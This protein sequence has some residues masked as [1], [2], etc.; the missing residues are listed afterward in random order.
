MR[1]QAVVA[2]NIGPG[3]VGEKRPVFTQH[4]NTLNRSIDDVAISLL[5][6]L[7]Q[8]L[9]LVVRTLDRRLRFLTL[10][11][12]ARE[13]A[14]EFSVSVLQKKHRDFER[15][16]TTILAPMDGLERIG[17]PGFDAIPGATPILFGNLGVD[18][19]DFHSGEILGAIV[20]NLAGVVVH[21][22]EMGVRSDPEDR[23]PGVV[24][25]DLG[26]MQR[27]V[28]LFA[29]GEI[30]GYDKGTA[31][32]Q[33]VVINTN[34]TPVGTLK[35]TSLHAVAEQFYPTRDLILDLSF[36]SGV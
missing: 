27:P 16:I 21:I 24:E 13:A 28:G 19:E 33:L 35:F 32:F 9:Q 31:G 36:R 29:R 1:S 18:V 5:G 7:P 10:G 15:N 2:V 14:G 4:Q 3:L 22:F 26:Q 34:P 11:D 25:G 30:R 20:E 6:E 17:A 12:V 8:S 23:F